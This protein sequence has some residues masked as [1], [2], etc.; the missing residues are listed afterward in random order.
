MIMQIRSYFW[1][2]IRLDWS[3]KSALN[4][5]FLVKIRFVKDFDSIGYFLMRNSRFERLQFLIRLGSA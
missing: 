4:S 3:A 5:K 1:I 2:S